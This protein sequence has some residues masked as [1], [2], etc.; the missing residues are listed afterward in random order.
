MR[1]EWHHQEEI[2]GK[3]VG[4]VR[5]GIYPAAKANGLL[6]TTKA[7]AEL[8]R[9]SPKKFQGSLAW[10]SAIN[11]IRKVKDKT[12]DLDTYRFEGSDAN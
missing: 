6:A 12:R 7:V 10:A 2:W 9:E 8:A 1:D 3:Q 4:D 5:W 11:D